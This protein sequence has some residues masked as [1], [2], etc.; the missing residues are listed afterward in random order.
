MKK[1]LSI[2]LAAVV[3]LSVF[4][5]LR[6]EAGGGEWAKLNEA[7]NVLWEIKSI[8]ENGMPPALLSSAYG[9]VVIPNMIKAGFILGGRYGQGVMV[10]RNSTGKWSNPCFVTITGGSVGWQAGAQSTDII[11]VFKTS[12]SASALAD[13]KFTL[14]A[15][16]SVAAG[17]V[18]R[19]AEAATD[20][21]LRAEILSYSRSRGLFAG[22]ALEGAA[23]QI[24]NSAN[25]FFYSKV[26]VTPWD[27]F[28]GR[29]IDP[30][31]EVKNF[32][33]VLER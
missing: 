8:P 15:D 11:L 26:G 10:I 12:R 5:P 25:A 16:A 22:V 33:N 3:V 14:G 24:D 9:V 4:V 29:G 32:I 17:P 20:A 27:I 19:H 7:A 28:D 2:C 23:L 1:T 21:Q 18:G 31:P 30:P 6:I 13:G